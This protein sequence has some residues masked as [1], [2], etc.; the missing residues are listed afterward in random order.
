[1]SNVLFFMT[2]Q[3]HADCLSFMGHPMV[4]TPNLDKLA[5]RSAV[6]RH[7]YT[8]TAICVPSR[9]SFHTGAYMRTHG[10][11]FNGG[12]LRQDMPSLVSVLRDHG[13]TSAQ[14]GKLHLPP[15]LADHYDSIWSLKQY[16]QD[17]AEAGYSETERAGEWKTRKEFFSFRS[18]LPEEWTNEVWTSQ[19][20]IDFIASDR[21]RQN[22]WFLWCSFERPHAPHSPPASFDNLYNPDEI[23]ID[24]DEYQRFEDSRLSNRPMM[25]DFWKIG[26]VR[27]DVGLF[28][29]AL[30][31]YF[32]LITLIDR[33]VGRVLKT[34]DEQGMADDTIVVFTSDHGDWAGQYGQIGKNLPA[35]DPLIRIPFIYCDPQRPADCGRDVEGLYQSVDL[36]PTLLER[37]GIDIPP[38]CQG[39]SF[40]P[41]LDGRPGSSR[42]YVFSETGVCKTIR[43]KQWKLNFYADHPE[44]GQLFQMTPR[45]DEITNHW[46]D[47]GLAHIKSRLMEQLMAW[48]VHCEQPGS[49]SSSWEQHLDTRWYHWLASRPKECVHLNRDADANL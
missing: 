1:M 24:W 22:P 15:T 13:Y 11:Y 31:R 33:E 25:E 32:A 45:P 23:P 20:A 3:Q 14:C 26:S 47:P 37:L 6:F 7:M 48:M 19:R 16:K 10:Q 41:A 38:S 28:Q 36:M 44:R 17:L 18:D 21:A 4:R 43:S 9:T 8:C 34:L 35:Y 30:C 2:D 39:V 49:L 12:D 5:E 40:L 29:K 42:N 27:H 46:D